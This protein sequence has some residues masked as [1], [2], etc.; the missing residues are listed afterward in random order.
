MFIII[1]FSDRTQRLQFRTLANEALPDICGFVD[2]LCA[3][4]RLQQTNLKLKLK[5]V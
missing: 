4:K 5:F 2:P 3:Y 1:G